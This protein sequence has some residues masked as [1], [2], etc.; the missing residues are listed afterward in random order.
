MRN[1]CQKSRQ[2]VCY[3]DCTKFQSGR[4]RCGYIYYT[5]GAHVYVKT[6]SYTIERDPLFLAARLAQLESNKFPDY[7][8]LTT[9]RLWTILHDRNIQRA[10]SESISYIIEEAIE[11]SHS[12]AALQQSYEDDTKLYEVW[13]RTNLKRWMVNARLA[14]RLELMLASKLECQPSRSYFL[15]L[16]E[17]TPNAI[18]KLAWFSDKNI[19][20]KPWELVYVQCHGTRCMLLVAIT[21]PA[22]S[23]SDESFHTD[24][25]D[26]RID[27]IATLGLLTPT[28]RQIR[29]EVQGVF[30][31]KSW[32]HILSSGKT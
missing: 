7:S 28:N 18:Y 30:W 14:Q 4:C 1:N 22:S 29:H 2:N 13:E 12:I 19:F 27:A 6:T 3:H 31:A 17:E 9:Y 15:D 26:E 5:S 10:N 32:Q 25:S 23:N 20:T 8:T 11:R 21:Q 24:R 16:P